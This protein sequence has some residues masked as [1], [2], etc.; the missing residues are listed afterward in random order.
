[1]RQRGITFRKQ[2]TRKDKNCK[3]FS[4]HQD[5]EECKNFLPMSSIMTP[6]NFAGIIICNTITIEMNLRV[7]VHSLISKNHRV[8]SL[9]VE[10]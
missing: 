5:C 8:S 6:Q 2:N 1:M 10:G 9:D 7:F 4:E 3:F